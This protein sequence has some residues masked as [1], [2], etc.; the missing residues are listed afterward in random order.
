MPG[1]SNAMYM[2]QSSFRSEMSPK[3]LHCTI[4]AKSVSHSFRVVAIRCIV[5]G[6][7]WSSS[8]YAVFICKPAKAV[9]LHCRSGGGSRA[10]LGL[11][12]T[13]A[14][15]FK[16]ARLVASSYPHVYIRYRSLVQDV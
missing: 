10:L 5:K 13:L 11:L 4:H 6:C 12:R 3:S 1:S 8:P 14:R 2:P 15:S 9:H 16:C 7:V